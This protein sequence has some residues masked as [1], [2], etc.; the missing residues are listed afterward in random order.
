[1]RS[2]LELASF[3]KRDPRQTER[4]RAREGGS[5]VFAFDK[6]A[7]WERMGFEPKRAC[8][9]TRIYTDLRPPGPLIT[10]AMDFP[11]MPPAER[12]GELIADLTAKP[13]VLGE[14]QMMRIR[15][16]ARANQTR[17]F[18]NKPHMLAV[19]NSA[20]LGVAQ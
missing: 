6:R 13:P 10:A 5:V 2:S 15:G 8:G 9:F 7:G 20:W 4:R 11:M 18:G 1:V 12:H 17:L 3:R 14:T 19:T 16:S